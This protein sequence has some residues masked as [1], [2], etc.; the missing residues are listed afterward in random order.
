MILFLCKGTVYENLD[1]IK[2]GEQPKQE[3][4]TLKRS[5]PN[6]GLNLVFYEQGDCPLTKQEQGQLGKDHWERIIQ[7]SESGEHHVIRKESPKTYFTHIK[8]IQYHRTVAAGKPAA[9]RGKLPF[10]WI[11]GPAGTGKTVMAENRYPNSYMKDASNKWW[12]GY[13]GE[14]SV[15]IDDLD[16][17]DAQK[18]MGKYLKVWCQHKPFLAEY[19]GGNTRYIRPKMIIVTCNW[20]TADIWSDPQMLQPINRRFKRKHVADDRKLNDELEILYI[21]NVKQDMQIVFKQIQA[22]R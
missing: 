10:L 13:N 6:Y 17:I 9:L 3:W 12:D 15:I 2:K 1:Y 8:T 18:Y 19:K 16:I 20:D 21:R 5:G 7:L 4:L 14:D 22:L 11:W